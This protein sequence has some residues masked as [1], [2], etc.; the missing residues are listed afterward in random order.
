MVTPTIQARQKYH[1]Q[2]VI[3]DQKDNIPYRDTC[4]TKKLYFP[5]LL[6]ER[7]WTSNQENNAKTGKHT[8]RNASKR[9]LSLRVSRNKC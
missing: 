2:Q 6:P 7:K 8:S 1:T 3:T 9:G 4:E 5:H